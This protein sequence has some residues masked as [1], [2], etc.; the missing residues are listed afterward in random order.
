MY[1]TGRGGCDN[2]TTMPFAPQTFFSTDFSSARLEIFE[3]GT[4]FGSVFKVWM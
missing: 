3:R 2:Q 4:F 1:R